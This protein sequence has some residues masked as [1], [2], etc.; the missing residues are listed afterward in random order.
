MEDNLTIPYHAPTSDFQ[1]VRGRT[2]VIAFFFGMSF[3]YAS[4]LIGG[5]WA[6]YIPFFAFAII[7]TFV[8]R[9]APRPWIFL[10]SIAAATPLFTPYHKFTCNIIYATL[11]ALFN[12]RYLFRLPRWIYVPTA[13][14]VVGFCISSFTWM[15]DDVAGGMLRQGAYA[16]NYIIAPFILLPII[17]L[18]MEKSRD[19]VANLQGLLFCLIVPSTIILISAKLFGTVYNAWEASLHISAGGLS[20]GFLQYKLSHVIVDFLRTEVG[21]ILAAL[22]C[23]SMAITISKVKILYRLLAGVCLS[24]NMLLLL[25]TASFGSGFA[26]ICGIAAIFYIQ[27][28]TVGVVKVFISMVAICGMMLLLYFISPPNIKIYL[29][30]RYEYRVVKADTDRFGMWVRAMKFCVD[31]PLGIGYSLSINEKGVKSYVHNDYLAYMV[32]YSLLGGLGY[33]SLVAGVLISFLQV[34]KNILKDPSAL[35]IYLAG[36]GVIVVV[37]VNSITDHMMENRWYFTL[38]W[39]VVW[40][41]YFCTR[42]GNKAALSLHASSALP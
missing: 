25:A 34:K 39:S 29:E 33:T 6:F 18:R 40:Y 9:N 31:H 8:W 22:I 38:I 14:A 13:L 37:A 10:V 3:I 35:T 26:C 23:A 24:V 12:A 5:K 28:R 41:S 32:S 15:S 21:F 4:I 16:F 20:E 2:S 17:Y 36:L 1:E 11:F 27:F 30:N 19:T 42:A 7:I